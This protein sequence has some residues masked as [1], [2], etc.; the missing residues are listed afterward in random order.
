MF[1]PRRRSGGAAPPP[2]PP[3]RACRAHEAPARG[4]RFIQ[5]RVGSRHQLLET[6]SPVP[7][8]DARREAL[9]TRRSLDQPPDQSLRVREAA[10]R[11]QGGE[12]IAARAD[13]E[14]GFSK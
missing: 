2:A 11:E 14:T 6:L 13:Q 1:C 7:F 3:A 9:L 12:L 4:L 8:G 5:P 10:L